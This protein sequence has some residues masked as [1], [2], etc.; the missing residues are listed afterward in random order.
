[1]RYL[2]LPLR[3]VWTLRQFYPPQSDYLQQP[4]MNYMDC[5]VL[6]TPP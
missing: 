6:I 2:D 5:A 3:Y 4:K 1:M